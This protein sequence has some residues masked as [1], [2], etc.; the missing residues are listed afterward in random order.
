MV[1]TTNCARIGQATITVALCLEQFLLILIVSQL[2][3]ARLS[4]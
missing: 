2:N 4:S 1:M 3:N